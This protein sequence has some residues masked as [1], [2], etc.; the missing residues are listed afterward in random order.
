MQSLLT[1]IAVVSYLLVS[2][3]TYEP[4][5]DS[6]DKRPL[7][8]WYDQAKVG[9]FLHWGVYSVPAMGEWFWKHWQG[10]SRMISV[11]IYEIITG[12]CII[13]IAEG[14]YIPKKFMIDNYRPGFTY[15]DFASEFTAKFFQPQDWAELFK[16]SGAK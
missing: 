14:Y 8:E 5:W 3:A 7:P 10:I 12:N 16:K 13:F 11:D 2:C 6:L 15:Q 1:V 9:I 4:S